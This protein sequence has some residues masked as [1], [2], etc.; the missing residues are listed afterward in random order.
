MLTAATLGMFLYGTYSAGT[1]IVDLLGPMSLDIWAD[2]MLIVLGGW[3]VLAAAFVR[4]GMPGCLAFAMAS[5]FALQALSLH[6]ASHL[7]G[8]IA[9]APELVRGAL[10]AILVLM[11]HVGLRR[12]QNTP[13]E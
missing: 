10:A 12:E 13:F 8:T 3:L 7:K 6:N 9:P 4:V 5:L 1:G 11:A 2:I